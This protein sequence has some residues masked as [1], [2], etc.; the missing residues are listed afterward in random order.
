LAAEEGEARLLAEEA[1]SADPAERLCIHISK[2][3][4]VDVVVIKKRI[5][6]TKT[7]GLK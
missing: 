2:C 7:V 1:S 3:G 5:E 6:K 4:S